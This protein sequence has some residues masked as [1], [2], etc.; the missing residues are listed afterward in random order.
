MYEIYLH[1]VFTKL[2]S[3]SHF[4]FTQETLDLAINYR[5]ADVFKTDQVSGRLFFTDRVQVTPCCFSAAVYPVG[6]ASLCNTVSLV[7]VPV[8]LWLPEKMPDNS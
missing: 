8:Q 1:R 4:P 5:T 7:C 3:L 2:F 6:K